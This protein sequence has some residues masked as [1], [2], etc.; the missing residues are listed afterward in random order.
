MRMCCPVVCLEPVYAQRA[1]AC[2]A[3]VHGVH[4]GP[5]HLSDYMLW[6]NLT[7]TEVASR[8]GRDRATISRIRR[9]VVR[10]DWPTIAQLKKM[11]RGEITA[12]DF[13]ELEKMG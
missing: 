3:P 1:H 8:I 7:D 13:I 11:S 10:P 12:D 2:Q 9:R 4:N 6:K 5:M